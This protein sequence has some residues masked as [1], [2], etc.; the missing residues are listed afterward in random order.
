MRADFYRWRN[1]RLLRRQTIAMFGQEGTDG[2]ILAEFDSAVVRLGSGLHT[3]ELS[4]EVR[5]NGPIR[6]VGN[7]GLRVD[8]NKKFYPCIWSANFSVRRGARARTS[9]R[10][11]ELHER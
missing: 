5:A 10:R 7:H 8:L 9:D 11:R 4:Q 6:L 3:A 1:N 2:W